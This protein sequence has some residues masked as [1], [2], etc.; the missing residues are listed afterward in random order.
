MALTAPKADV[1]QTIYFLTLTAGILGW[2]LFQSLRRL[3]LHSLPF[4]SS[5]PLGRAY[6][7]DITVREPV[8]PP[9]STAYRRPAFLNANSIVQTAVLK[10]LMGKVPQLPSVPSG[11]RPSLVVSLSTYSRS[12]VWVC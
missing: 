10:K 12:E 11:G 4:K 9:V 2:Y 7:S 8:V 5:P 6:V 3:I 1:T